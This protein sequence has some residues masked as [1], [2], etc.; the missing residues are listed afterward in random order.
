MTEQNYPPQYYYQPPQ[1][2][3]HPRTGLGIAAMCC[4][5]VAV[6]LALIPVI[7]LV[8]ILLGLTAIVLGILAIANDRG[9]GQGVAGIVTGA[10]GLVVSLLALWLLNYWLDLN[11]ELYGW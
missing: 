9:R 1:P 3:A 11:A 6:G 8:S 7:G 2:Q 5:I 10:A 4:G